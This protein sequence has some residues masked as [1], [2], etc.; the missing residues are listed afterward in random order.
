MNDAASVMM[1]CPHAGAW[2]QLGKS[3]RPVLDRD[4]GPICVKVFTM[5][6]SLWCHR[7]FLNRVSCCRRDQS[8]IISRMYL[9]FI[10]RIDEP[11]FLDPS[12]IKLP[13]CLASKTCSVQ[14][15][16]VWILHDSPHARGNVG[17]MSCSTQ[18]TGAPRQQRRMWI[19]AGLTACKAH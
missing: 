11:S 2:D 10:T 4:E 19:S 15:L 7:R 5:L 16:E 13:S 8:G 17:F 18:P 12:D 14:W 6:V 9:L 3:V 1:V